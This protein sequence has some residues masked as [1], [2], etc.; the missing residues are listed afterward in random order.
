MGKPVPK[1]A[2]PISVKKEDEITR[3]IF[4]KANNILWFTDCALSEREMGNWKGQISSLGNSVQELGL[5]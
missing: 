5:D 3:I 1:D 2:L 4:P